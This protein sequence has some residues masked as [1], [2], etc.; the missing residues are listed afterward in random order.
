[1]RWLSAG[2]L[3]IYSFSSSNVYCQNVFVYVYKIRLSRLLVKKFFINAGK[4]E[5]L[6]KIIL[7]CLPQIFL[8]CIQ[9]GET[10]AIDRTLPRWNL[11][12][13][14]A[15]LNDWQGEKTL[16]CHNLP[17]AFFPEFII[18]NQQLAVFADM[19]IR[20]KAIV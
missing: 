1:M 6:V 12:H 20:I 11:F 19:V 17:T 15:R 8:Q 18:G 10:L 16:I 4:M 13:R 9:K 2:S 3:F 7:Q 5:K 14:L